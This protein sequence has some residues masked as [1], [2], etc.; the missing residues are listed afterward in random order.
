M[1]EVDGAV[2][3]AAM[4]GGEIDGLDVAGRLVT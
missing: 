2:G 1:A 4:I 3:R